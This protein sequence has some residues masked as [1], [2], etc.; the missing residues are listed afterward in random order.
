[1]GIEFVGIRDGLFDEEIIGDVDSALKQKD[2]IKLCVGVRSSLE[3]IL[4]NAL[5]SNNIVKFIRKGNSYVR[6][7]DI[8]R[9]VWNKPLWRL[10]SEAYAADIINNEQFKDLDEIKKKCDNI[11][12]N[13]SGVVLTDDGQKRMVSD[14][15]PLFKHLLDINNG[16]RKEWKTNEEE[17]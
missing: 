1:M 13:A 14:V 5:T 16:L 17:T 8:A 12:H 3:I 15:S 10:L 6:P 7:K 9:S 2:S 11:I 4:K